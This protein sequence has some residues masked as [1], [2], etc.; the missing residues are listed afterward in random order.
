MKSKLFYYIA[1][2]AIFPGLANSKTIAEREFKKVNSPVFVI[3]GFANFFAANSNQATS[4]QS[5]NL[6]DGISNNNLSDK[7]F[8]GNDT[9]IFLKTGIKTANKTKYGAVA[10]IEFNANSS[11]VNQKPNLDQ[12][13][14]FSEGDFGKFEF[15]NYVAVNQKMKV[16]P[17]RFA[18]GAGGI[19]GKYLEYVNLPML[20]NSNQSSSAACMGNA[21]SGAC[22][23]VKLPRFILLAQSP[24]GH[25]GD[26][27]SFHSRAVDNN[28][29]ANSASY[30]AF[31]RSNFRTLK[32]N[33]FE[34]IEDATKLSYYSPRI[35]GAQ[36]GLSYTPR[37]NNNG[38]TQ[39]TIFDSNQSYIENIFTLGANYSHDFDNVNLLLSATAEKGQVKNSKSNNAVERDDLLAYDLG[40]SLS[41]FGF[42]IG[43]SYGSWGSSLEAKNGIY[44]CDYNSSQNLSNQN[45]TSNNQKFSNPYYYTL[46]IAYRFGPIS[47]S[48]TS[49]KSSYQK[50]D[51]RTYSLGLDYKL[52]RDLMPYV[53]LTKFA[54][55]SN[56]ISA[57]DV[58]NQG[59]VNNSQRQIRNNNGYVFLTGILYSF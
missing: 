8:V 58:T 7:N 13:H 52:K 45:C 23:N 38:F 37:S 42:E 27:K 54:F 26:A 2:L 36:I 56:Q 31:N 14:L 16:G 25:G 43:A 47:A 3:D 15:G 20:S 28:Y 18:R 50:N 55:K 10:K 32:D 57:L 46:G 35:K 48:L 51:Y 44:S 5:K 1:I 40:F 39:T 9:Q 4:F 19:N 12:A 29:L 33:S 49:L 17:A 22:S 41:Y 11:R 30:G 21:L 24:V 53:E 59:S 6:P 34:G